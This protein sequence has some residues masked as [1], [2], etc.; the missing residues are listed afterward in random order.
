MTL[1]AI[2]GL[3]NDDGEGAMW[4]ERTCCAWFCEE[5]TREKIESELSGDNEIKTN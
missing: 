2:Y 3:L 1:I 5:L 4:S